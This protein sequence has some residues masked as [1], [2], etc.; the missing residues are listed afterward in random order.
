MMLLLPRRI[1]RLLIIRLALPCDSKALADRHIRLRLGHQRITNILSAAAH[2]AVKVASAE[3]A[4]GEISR[5][6]EELVW[7]RRRL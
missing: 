7:L 2:P 3:R 1:V 5:V 4:D 6:A